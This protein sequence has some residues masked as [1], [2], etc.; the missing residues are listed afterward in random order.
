M[1]REE[2]DGQVKHWSPDSEKPWV[3]IWEGP[4]GR[5]MVNQLSVPSADCEEVLTTPDG[6]VITNIVAKEGGNYELLPQLFGSKLWAQR[7]KEGHAA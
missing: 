3:D 2:F 4:G 5:L 7:Q 6:D 1:Y